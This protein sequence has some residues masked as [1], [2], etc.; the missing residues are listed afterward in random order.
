MSII[1]NRAKIIKFKPIHS[2]ILR[3]RDVH[4]PE[5]AM[6]FRPLFQISPLFPKKFSE[7]VVNFCFFQK[8]LRFSSA[9]I[10]DDL[11]LVIDY[12]FE[13]PPCFRSFSTFPPYFAYFSKFPPLIS[14]N[15][16]VF[17]ILYVFFVS[18]Y[19]DHDAFMHHTMHVLDAPAENLYRAPSRNYSK[20]LP[21]MTKEKGLERLVEL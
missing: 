6:H 13:F 4:P 12:K 2:F 15:L 21:A 8:I 11:F 18:P 17:Y 3:T 20:A 7:S 1:E 9:K 16:P 5:A 14:Y 19:F 10:S